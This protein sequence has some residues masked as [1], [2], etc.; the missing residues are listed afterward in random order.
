[1]P[2]PFRNHRQGFTLIELMVAIGILLVLGVMIIGFLRGALSMSRT[3]TSR[4]KAYETAQTT[5]RTLQD[6]LEQVL[7]APAHPTGD[8]YDLAFGVTQDPWGRQI[9]FFTRA[10]GEEQSSLAG[11]DS[12]RGAPGQG[13]SK[14]FS[15]RNVGDYMRPSRGNLEVVWM[16][17][18]SGTG[19]KL[20]RAERSPPGKNGLID[21][22]GAW[23]GRYVP[24]NPGQAVGPD[25][26]VPGAFL[27]ER[28]LGLDPQPVRP[29]AQSIWDQFDLVAD[30]V[31]SLSVECWD[32]WGGKTQ[33]WLSGRDGPSMTWSLSGRVAAGQYALPRA[34]R[35]TLI[36]AADDPIAAQSTMLG[37]LGAQDTSIALEDTA[38]FPDVISPLAYLR[39]DGELMGYASKSGST[40]GSLSRGALGTKAVPHKAG[41]VVASG[42]GFQRIIQFPVSR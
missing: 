12:G 8:T 35:V 19:M 31:V 18:P 38:N 24:Q 28:G 23:L 39:V 5:L 21:S 3:G 7:G 40:I 17:E 34:I 27:R 33:T 20:Y 10:W 32:D 37:D 41:A 2:A 13:Y 9:L 6:D 36:V 29:P 15:G 42:F 4:G 22:I 30:N 25:D 11:Y 1:M 14:D 16:L 26:P